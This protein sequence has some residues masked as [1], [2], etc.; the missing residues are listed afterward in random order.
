MCARHVYAN[1]KEKYGGAEYEDMFWPAADSY[2]PQQFDRKM[3]ELKEYDPAAFKDLKISL[4]FPWSRAYFTEFSKCA[5]V[6][7]NLGESFNAAI[8]IARTKPVVEMLEEI[9]K[10]VMVGYFNYKTNMRIEGFVVHMQ[11]EI[12]CS[13]RMYMVSGIPCSHIVSCL[14]HEKNTD[15]DP[16]KMISPWFTAQKLKTCYA[17]GLCGVNGMN[18]WEV[19]TTVRV[20][21][22]PYKMPGGR[23]PEKKRKREKGEPREG[24]KLSKKG[25]KIHCS[26][27]GQEGHNKL[28]CKNGPMPKLPKKAPGRP[29]KTSTAKTPFAS[30]STSERPR[31]SR[32]SQPYGPMYLPIEGYGLFTSP[33]TG[34][35]YIQVGRESYIYDSS[36][37]KATT[38]AKKLTLVPLIF[39]I[40]FEVA[41]GPFGE[42]PAVQAAGPLLAI[43]GFLIFPFIWS[44]PEALITAE[45]ST[46]FPGNG[47]FV[48]WA[49]RAFGSFVGSMMGSLKFL[50]GVI[51]VASFPVLCVTYLD[52]LFPVLESGWPRNVCIFASTVVLSFLN[53]T[54]LAIVGYTAVVLGLVSLSPFLVMSAMAI[55]KIKP[56]RWGSLGDKK[57]DWNLYFNT[58]FWNL[59][60]WDNVS[61]LAG[62][63]DKPQKTFPLALLIAVIF[64]CIAYLIP[65]FAVT[66]AVSVDQSRWETGFH[67]E[68]AE[69]IAG[70][71]LKIWIEIGAVLSSI[72]LFEAQLSSSAYQLE[73]MAELGFLP[74]FFGV[75]SKW[76]NTPWLG[77][78]L[79]ALMSLGLSYLD[80]TDIISAANFLY[81]LGMFLE[82]ASFIWLRKKLPELK[83]PYR[84]PLKIPGLVIMCLIPSGFLVLI[85]V[86]A[87][88]IVYLICGLMTVGAIGWYF[89][90]NY[91]RKKKIFEFNEVNDDLD[92]NVNGEEHPKVDDHES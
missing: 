78:L 80:F 35:D 89:L 48:I 71:W 84:V 45:L 51:N 54:G 61:T 13:Y 69:M 36:S 87:T 92:Y 90:I 34:D 67:A 62:E 42:E 8:H 2:Y 29:R 44:V 14:R 25:T 73:G 85:I 15:Q 23:P 32:K 11:G 64:T 39:L 20:L 21:P 17:D 27:C 52:K 72:G 50:S 1:W 33:V 63:V 37:N 30:T 77:I 86:F 56:H 10:R 88:K 57:K 81:T 7:N 16:K 28:K 49:H 46:A 6:E 53:Y 18:L 43:L 9:R 4:F 74:K 41:G 24:T 40:Y 47:G 31:R 59:N 3:Q 70:K 58:L 19:T 68:A 38:A 66:G 76:F 26:L 60:F 82:F 12:K 75:R 79:S 91:F 83:R 55:P 22:P 65:L 5:A